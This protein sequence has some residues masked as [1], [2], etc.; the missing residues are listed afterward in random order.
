MSRRESEPLVVVVVM[1]GTVDVANGVPCRIDRGPVL[2]KFVAEMAVY[3]YKKGRCLK[4]QHGVGVEGHGE[5][6]DVYDA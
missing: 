2:R 3:I 4:G 5:D 1:A 6:A